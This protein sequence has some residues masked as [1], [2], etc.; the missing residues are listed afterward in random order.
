MPSAL[1]ALARTRR[2]GTAPD[3]PASAGIPPERRGVEHGDERLEVLPHDDVERNGERGLVALCVDEGGPIALGEQRE[4]EGER[5]E[6]DG[7]G[8]CAGAAA[9]GHGGEARADAAVEEAAGK[10]HERAEEARRRDGGRERDQAGQEEQ[11][12]PCAL[13][14]VE[15]R[16]VG[17][18][19][20]E[21]RD[22]DR[23]RS[24]GRP[25]RAGRSGPRPAPAPR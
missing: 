25:R 15:S 21:R 19:A 11:D 2:T 17:G 16:L 18:A 9:E 20:G 8:S 23:E 12:E 14:L 6:R 13:A 1:P 24:R 10:A 4:R 3:P 7:D 22:D 5:E